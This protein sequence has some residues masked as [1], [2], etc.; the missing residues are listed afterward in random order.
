MI[1]IDRADRDH[2]ELLDP[3]HWISSQW[4]GDT[5]RFCRGCI[6]CQTNP[7]RRDELHWTCGGSRK[8]TDARYGVSVCEDLDDLV[9]YFGQIGGVNFDDAVLVELAG[10]YSD[11]DGHDAHLGEELILPTEIISITPMD[12]DIADRILARVEEVHG[13]YDWDDYQT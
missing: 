2:S 1:R 4:G 13:A 9:E 6:D 12:D 5:L 11:D 10:E 8:V 7:R 3:E